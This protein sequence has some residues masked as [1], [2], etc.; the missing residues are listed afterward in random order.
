MPELRRATAEP[1]KF[2][3]DPRGLVIE[4]LHAE[5]FPSQKNAHLVLTVP[6]GIRGNHY[7]IHGTEIA[8]VLGPALIRLRDA[9]GLRDYDLTEGQAC[10]FV[11]PAGVPHAMLNT[12]T[13]L[14]VILSFNTEVHDPTRP[15]VVRDVL[16]EPR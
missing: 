8:V 10:R 14:M 12:G 3:T 9:D 11:L 7:H 15:D 6:G 16:I 4:P 1:M 5:E 2:P 13:A